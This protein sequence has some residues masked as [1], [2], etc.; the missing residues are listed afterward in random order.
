MLESDFAIFLDE[1]RTANS[2]TTKTPQKSPKQK[3]KRPHPEKPCSNFYKLLA[4]DNEFC[5]TCGFKPKK[6][7]GHDEPEHDCGCCN[8]DCLSS[9]PVCEDYECPANLFYTEVVN[10][11][12]FKRIETPHARLMRNCIFGLEWMPYGLSLDDIGS[13]FGVSREFIRQILVRSLA[14]IGR[15]IKHKEEL[16]VLIPDG[17]SLKYFDAFIDKN[18]NKKYMRSAAIE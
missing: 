14:K 18:K 10:R 17:G 6:E 13:M 15:K 2:S 9:I 8:H 5:D 1:L 4:A 7:E 11:G 12:R 3:H 16:R